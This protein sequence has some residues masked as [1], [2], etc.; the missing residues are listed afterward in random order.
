MRCERCGVEIAEDKIAM[1]NRC[2]DWRCPT[3]PADLRWLPPEKRRLR[4]QGIALATNM[5]FARQ[6]EAIGADAMNVEAG[7]AAL[8]EHEARQRE[9]AE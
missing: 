3:M 5:M 4:A 9:A 2:T 7:L 1:P 6:C 8:A